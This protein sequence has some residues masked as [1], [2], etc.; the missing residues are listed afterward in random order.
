MNGSVSY[1]TCHVKRETPSGKHTSPQQPTRGVAARN[2]NYRASPT[3]EEAGTISFADS[4]TDSLPLTCSLSCAS[5]ISSIGIPSP[6]SRRVIVRALTI[7]PSHG[8]A[9]M[10]P[11]V[12]TC[13][14]R[15]VARGHRHS[16]DSTSTRRPT[17]TCLVTMTPGRDEEERCKPRER[18]IMIMCWASIHGYLSLRLQ[19]EPQLR[20][21][22]TRGRQKPIDSHPRS[23]IGI[24]A[25]AG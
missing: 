23:P 18:D 14:L 9:C 13:I 16:I 8:N 11:Y 3:P 6:A 25:A 4:Q 19:R 21:S 15:H 2:T 22:D 24:R 7:I 12:S 20:R 17:A 1:R 10:Y 5:S